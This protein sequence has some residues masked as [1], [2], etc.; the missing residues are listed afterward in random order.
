MASDLTAHGSVFISYSRK[1][2]DF[3]NRLE[4]RL[5]A[6]NFEVLIDRNSIYALE[7]WRKRIEALIVQSD[8]V[9]FVLSPDAVA[10][11]ECENE[12]AFAASLNK[13]FAPVV[14]RRVLD[15]DVPRA[16]AELNY[17]FFD[18]EVIEKLGSPCR[19]AQYRHFLDPAAYPVWPAGSTLGFGQRADRIAL[20]LTGI[21]GGGTMDRIKTHRRTGGDRDAT[22]H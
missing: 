9:V 17:I 8:T 12:V 18:D 15:K 19:G 21:G 7:P 22:V 10:S 13:R 4:A 1:D 14:Y 3:A 2:M 5:K 11:K 20:A 6:R 16:L